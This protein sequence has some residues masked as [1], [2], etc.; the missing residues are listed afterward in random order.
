MAFL[1]GEKKFRAR[2]RLRHRSMLT[3]LNM[4]LIKN[5]ITVVPISPI[6][7]VCQEKNLN[8]GL[9]LGADARSRPRHARLTAA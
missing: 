3:A 8:E 7:Q 4:G 6:R 5:I 9:K 1:I 2:I